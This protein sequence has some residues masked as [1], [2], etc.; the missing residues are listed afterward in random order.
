MDTIIQAAEFIEHIAT[1][2]LDL[3]RIEEGKISL[4]MTEVRMAVLMHNLERSA[5]PL[6]KGRPAVDFRIQFDPDICII[7]TD[8]YRLEQVLMNFISNAFKHTETGVIKISAIFISSQWIRISV[9][10][11][12]RGVDEALKQR[13][14][15]EFSQ[16]S[17]GQ[18]G[19]FGL[20]LCLAK[21]LAT[22]LGGRV[23]FDS[24]YGAGSCFWIEMPLGTGSASLAIS[25]AETA[26]PLERK[27]M[28][29]SFAGARK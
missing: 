20:G 16:G 21:M 25:F 29:L 26:L 2:I 24:V 12:G 10:D 8:R 19:G 18:F 11:T 3:R 27:G 14:F 23:G 17:A 15:K 6:R 9:S 5:V 7:R 1:D 4:E 22:L 28:R 13:L